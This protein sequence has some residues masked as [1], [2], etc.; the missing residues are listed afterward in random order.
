MPRTKKVVEEVVKV[1]KPKTIK[2]YTF[3]L[4][5]GDKVLKG[6]GASVLE[7]LRDI[8]EPVKM[9]TKGD[10]EVSYGKKKAKMT[11]VPAKVKRL[12]QKIAQ[13]VLAKQFTSLLK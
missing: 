3:Q 7:A 2:G 4:T 9:F 1:I 12:F 11:W 8:E 5:L 6:K 13:P 10:I